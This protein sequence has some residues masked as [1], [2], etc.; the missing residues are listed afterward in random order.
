MSQRVL[1]FA[2]QHIGLLAK[3]LSGVILFRIVSYF[4]AL[5]N[6][7]MYSG[8]YSYFSVSPFTENNFAHINNDKH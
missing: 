1:F 2:F 8:S 4:I 7:F 3:N 5:F 6:I